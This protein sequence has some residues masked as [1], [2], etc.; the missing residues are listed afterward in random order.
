MA[1]K[2][3]KAETTNNAEFLSSNTAIIIFV[4][5]AC[6]R[7][8]F[9]HE[10]E[11]WAARH[12]RNDILILFKQTNRS[13]IKFGLRPTLFRS[14][15]WKL[16]SKSILLRIRAGH[17]MSQVR[18]WNQKSCIYQPCAKSS[19][20]FGMRPLFRCIPTSGTANV[21]RT[22]DRTSTTWCGAVRVSRTLHQST[23]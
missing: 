22:P 14:D 5:V 4:F 23:E 9:S 16:S 10:G 7:R 2:A 6:L 13:V 20:R 12:E 18:N 8:L 11:E 21:S 17:L 19:Q 15:G 3:S 1:S